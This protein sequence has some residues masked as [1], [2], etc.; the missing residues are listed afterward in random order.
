MDITPRLSSEPDSGQNRTAILRSCLDI[1]L[2]YTPGTELTDQQETA[3]HGL[4]KFCLAAKT[5][6]AMDQRTLWEP[7]AAEESAV[8]SAFAAIQQKLE[9]RFMESLTRPLS[10][11]ELFALGYVDTL[12]RLNCYEYC[13]VIKDATCPTFVGGGALPI[14]A[15]LYVLIHQ[16][17]RAHREKELHDLLRMDD[18]PNAKALL[19]EVHNSTDR[20]SEFTIY[21]LDNDPVQVRAATENL[22]EL[23]LDGNLS[24]V[25][26]NGDL[27]DLEPAADGIVIASTVSPKNAVLAH[28]LQH[29]LA[30]GHGKVLVRTVRPET[31]DAFLYEPVELTQLAT[32]CS[33]PAIRLRHSSDE[34]R[35]SRGIN[36]FVVFEI[37]S[38]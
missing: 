21:V 31:F 11:R 6:P 12:I 26:T 32:L 7:F 13:Q 2:A 33:S 36:D 30:L 17:F 23:G 27:P 5:L 16:V 9:H 19:S 3:Y 35:D 4:R 1:I 15:I 14:S 37:S 38:N 28:V 25:L 34:E 22:I 8:R 24:L 18:I 29:P 10:L 20:D